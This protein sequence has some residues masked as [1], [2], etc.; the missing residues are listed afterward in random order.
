MSM[1]TRLRWY[2]DTRGVCY[3][4]VHHARSGSSL[5]SARAARVPCGR[6]AKSIVLEDER[7]YLLAI[8]PA[9]CRLDMKRIRTRL[10]RPLQLA[11]EAELEVLFEDCETGAIPAIGRAYGIPALIDDSLMRLPDL[12]FDA[13]DHEDL[14]HLSG[15][16][17]RALLAGS[18]HG[19]IGRPDLA[20]RTH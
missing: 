2:L 14:V 11:T 13:G 1:A 16:A 19:P 3:E 9:S 7:G 20:G 5:E 8:L 17:F 15:S 12:Y 10:G 18:D 6:V 4:I